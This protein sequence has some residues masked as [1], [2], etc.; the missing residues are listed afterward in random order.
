MCIYICNLTLHK[1][2]REIP[3]FSD[4]DTQYKIINPLLF[5]KGI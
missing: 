4:T 3:A 1:Y 2:N 5:S